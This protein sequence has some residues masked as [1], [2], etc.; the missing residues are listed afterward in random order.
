[1]KI[2]EI[3]HPDKK[4]IESFFYGDGNEE[5]EVE[6]DTG[7]VEVKAV[8]KTVSYQIFYLKEESHDL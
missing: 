5:W 2:T 7:W 1:M 6:T 4:F 8:G 3:E